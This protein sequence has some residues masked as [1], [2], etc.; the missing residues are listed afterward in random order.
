MCSIAFQV[1]TMVFLWCCF[2]VVTLYKIFAAGY[3]VCINRYCQ[4]GLFDD[5]LVLLEEMKNSNVELDERVFSTILFA[6]ARAGN[7]NVGKVF[8]KFL[9]ENNIGMDSY[10]QNALVNMY[11]SCGAMDVAQRLYDELSPKNVVA[12]TAM[13]CG[14]S[15]VGLV[16]FARSIFDQMVE[17]D[18]ICWSAMI[19][20][21]AGSD[22]PQEALKLFSEMQLFGLNPDQITMLSVISACANLGALEQA[23]EIHMYARKHG[24]GEALPINNALIDMYAK[25][26]S[27]DGARE[28][29]GRMRRKN[30]I[31]WTSMINAFAVHGDAANALKLFSQMKEEN[32]DPNWVT[33]VGVLYACSHAGLVEEGRKIFNSMVN[34]YRIT[35]KHEHYGCLVDLYGR[36]NLLREALEVVENMPLA[37]MLLSGVP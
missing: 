13:V 31:S 23:K 10:I 9:T 2:H 20:G 32:V 29:F 19:S 36:A 30:V 3:S 17:K 12:S 27:L 6:C 4:S 24:I 26:G 35:P 33:F 37:P 14:Y 1:R 25:C 15:K 21:Y 22:E 11:A 18:L 5:V 8:H 16:E 34:E 28:V 7:L